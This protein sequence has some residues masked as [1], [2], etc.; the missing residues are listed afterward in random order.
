MCH[1]AGGVGV[2]FILDRSTPN[3]HLFTV[4]SLDGKL[5]LNFTGVQNDFTS[6]TTVVLVV[7]VG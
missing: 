7:K 1:V 4:S 6:N 3:A 5:G 2:E